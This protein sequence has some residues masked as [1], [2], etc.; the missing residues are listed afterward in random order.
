[1]DEPA[2]PPARGAEYHRREQQER[3][4]IFPQ[5]EVQA[6]EQT[7]PHGREQYM[8]ADAPAVN[9][10]HVSRS[11]EALDL[12]QQIVKEY[13]EV[14][15]LRS[16]VKDALKAFMH[17]LGLPEDAELTACF[18]ALK[19]TAGRQ[20]RI[21]I[22]TN[23]RSTKPLSMETDETAWQNLP[24]AEQQAVTHFQSVL[25]NSFVFRKMKQEKVDAITERLQELNTPHYQSQTRDA[26]D[27]HATLKCIPGYIKCF[28]EEIDR[29][30]HDVELATPCLEDGPQ[31]GLVS[32]LI[33]PAEQ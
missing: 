11:P 22:E 23:K 13:S 14:V 20:S 15:E 26:R 9:L 4:A 18:K 17:N 31:T 19:E 6:D 21:Q 25:T 1:M 10:P 8:F 24:R 30:L 3:V 29:L 7:N 32:I 27:M 28:T 5:D 12:A 16:A 33:A 2:P